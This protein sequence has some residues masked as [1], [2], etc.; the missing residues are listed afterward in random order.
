MSSDS[1]NY[2]IQNIAYGFVPSA[3]AMSV[4]GCT[5]S[6]GGVGIRHLVLETPVFAANCRFSFSPSIRGAGPMT[7]A[8]A[9]IS[10]G[11]VHVDDTH[12]DLFCATGAGVPALVDGDYDF[13][14]RAVDLPTVP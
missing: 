6:S 5:I 3:G 9:S 1:S 8:Q 4:R 14:I 12:K 10:V 7:A 13:T 2:S 11:I